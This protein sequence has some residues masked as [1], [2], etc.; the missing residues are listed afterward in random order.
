LI[1]NG[2]NTKEA[3]SFGSTVSIHILQVNGTEERPPNKRGG[4]RNPQEAA[5]VVDLVQELVGLPGQRDENWNSSDRIRIIEFYQDQVSLIKKKMAEKG[6]HGVL[7]ATVDSSQGC[8]ADV[9]I[10]SFVRSNGSSAGFL[11]D[12]RR[13][14]VAMTRARHQLVAWQM[15]LC[16]VS[17]CPNLRR[18][19]ADAIVARLLFHTTRV[20]ST[21]QTH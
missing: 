13:M 2:S 10:L 17:G 15:H 20:L 1:A 14:N 5:V 12:D 21:L 19:C 16:Q 6:L 18:L 4:L 7:V 11:R 3:R 9:V 8:E